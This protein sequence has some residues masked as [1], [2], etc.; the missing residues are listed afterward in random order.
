M[1]VSTT[2]FLVDVNNPSPIGGLSLAGSAFLHKTPTLNWTTEASDVCGIQRY[3]MAIGTGNAGAAINN[4][5]DWLSVGTPSGTYSLESGVAGASF[6]LARDSSYYISIRAIDNNG[7][8][9]A[10]STSSVFST[11]AFLTLTSPIQ[12]PDK[13]ALTWTTPTTPG[14]TDYNIYYRLNLSLIHI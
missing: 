6:T 11:T 10:V 2:P 13:I 3:E 12:F 1:A 7:R 5:M 9:S 14:I 4:T 8:I